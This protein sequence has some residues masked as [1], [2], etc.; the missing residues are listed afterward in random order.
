MDFMFLTVK[1]LKRALAQRNST[2]HPTLE[3]EEEEEKLGDLG[4]QDTSSV[5]CVLGCSAAPTSLGA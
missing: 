1:P 3:D 5:G 4:R 2:H